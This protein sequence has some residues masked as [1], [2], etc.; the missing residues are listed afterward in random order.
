LSRTA[1]RKALFARLFIAD[2]AFWVE[3]DRKIALRIFDLIE[4]TR[5]DPFQGIGKPEPLRHSLTGSWARR[6]N[7]QH[8]IVY[9]VT[10]AEIEFLQARYHY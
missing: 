3:T 7:Q 10:E 1:E 6:I 5:R 9:A 4:A 2:L 8:R